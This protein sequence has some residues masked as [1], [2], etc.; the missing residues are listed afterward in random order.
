VITTAG[1]KQR[2]VRQC[3]EALGIRDTQYVE[4]ESTY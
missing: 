4:V 3:K 2:K 1:E